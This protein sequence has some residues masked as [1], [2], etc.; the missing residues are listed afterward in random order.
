MSVIRA[1]LSILLGW[2]REKP[3]HALTL[4]D[5]WP[6]GDPAKWPTSVRNG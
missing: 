6:K 1:F 4:Y 3:K 5:T 2:L